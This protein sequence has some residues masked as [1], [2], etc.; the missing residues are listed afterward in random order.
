[1]H[2]RMMVA[3]GGTADETWIRKMIEHHR[4]AIEMSNLVI[5]RGRNAQAKAEARKGI[6]E[7]Q[8]DIATLQA[9][10]RR[11]GKRAQ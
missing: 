5:S 10:L 3:L 11:M 7:Q 8:K 9:M 2:E 4:G 1:M 6:V